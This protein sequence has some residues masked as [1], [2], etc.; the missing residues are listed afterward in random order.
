MPLSF[1][2]QKHVPSAVPIQTV[3]R[4]EN[5]A[6][7]AGMDRYVPSGTP[8]LALYDALRESVPLLSAAIGKLVRLT[9]GFS[10]HC[11][12]PD[13]EAAL[14]RFLTDVPLAGCGCGVHAFLSAYLD[15]MLT[16]GT[17]AQ[18][19]FDY[20]TSELAGGAEIKSFEPITADRFD[21]DAIKAS[22]TEDDTIPVYYTA[23]NVTLGGEAVEGT[24]STNGAYRF[25]VIS[26]QNIVLTDIDVPM[27]LVVGSAGTYAVSVLNYFAAAEEAGSD[28]LKYLTRALCAYSQAAKAIAN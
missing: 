4:Q 7:F 21:T 24:I 14:Q 27:D 16:Y 28:S 9:I 13:A 10:A 25:I 23:M 17:A 26:K 8:T 15:Q 6:L 5:Y 2:K 11:T 18:L 12:A 1:K 22:M 19:Y 20:E 3:P